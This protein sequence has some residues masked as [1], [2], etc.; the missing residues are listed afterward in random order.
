MASET[1]IYQILKLLEEYYLK[2]REKTMSGAQ[3]DLYLET[4][5]DIPAQ[6]LKQAAFNWIKR[7]GTWFPKVNELRA[8]AEKIA[9]VQHGQSMAHLPENPVNHLQ[10]ELYWLEDQFYREGQ[11]IDHERWQRLIG[12]YERL[13]LEYMLANTRKRYQNLQTVQARWD[14]EESAPLPVG[15]LKHAAV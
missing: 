6:I 9:N 12:Q 8:F 14:A 2:P 1:E 4:L 11:P 10:A 15:E 13:G 3:A 7:E 5:G